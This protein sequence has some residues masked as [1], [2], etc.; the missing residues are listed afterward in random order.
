MDGRFRYI[1]R[2]LKNSDGKEADTCLPQD[3]SYRAITPLADRLRR[4]HTLVIPKIVIRDPTPPDD[5]A[6]RRLVV[7]R[8]R[9]FTGGFRMANAKKTGHRA[10]PMGNAQIVG[11][12][13]GTLLE[14]LPPSARLMANRSNDYWAGCRKAFLHNC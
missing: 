8:W 3:K 14:P 1:R 5:P 6:H 13:K 10:K 2:D 12:H 9:R 11:K 4:I 7:N